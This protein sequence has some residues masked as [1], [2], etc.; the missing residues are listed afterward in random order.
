MR[1]KKAETV[2][3]SARLRAGSLVLLAAITLAMAADYPRLAAA[4]EDAH[5]IAADPTDLSCR[6]AASEPDVAVDQCCRPAGTCAIHLPPKPV[7]VGIV[8]TASRL[9][10]NRRD[11]DP[12][13]PS[14]RPFKPP[15]LQTRA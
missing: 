15:R 9:S 8:V 10:M 5:Q 7:D 6:L 14:Y 11:R 1:R 2:W 4:A 3:W 12:P 13:S